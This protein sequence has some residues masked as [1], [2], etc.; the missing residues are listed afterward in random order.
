MWSGNCHV[1][2]VNSICVLCFKTKVCTKQNIANR[3]ERKESHF[4]IS[5]PVSFQ[6]NRGTQRRCPPK[7]I[8]NRP[9]QATQST[10][11]FARASVLYYRKIPKII[12][13][14]YSFQRP[15]L[16]GLYW[17]GNLR[18]KIGQAYTWREICVS[19]SRGLAYSQKEMYVVLRTQTFLKHSHASSPSILC[20]Y[21]PKKPKP[22]VRSELRKQK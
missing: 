16:R 10:N 8:E 14:A 6:I 18:F 9:F 3:V 13:G 17:E 19:K 12:S 11:R 15:F 20:L 2:C 21:G 22:R 7:C 5:R 4:E 1:F